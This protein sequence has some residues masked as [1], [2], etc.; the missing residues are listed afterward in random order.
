MTICRIRLRAVAAVAAMTF[1]SAALA[2]AQDR[3]GDR[4]TTY[5][6][7]LKDGSRCTESSSRRTTPASC[8]AVW[9]AS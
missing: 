8:F 1:L 9:P 6:L 7:T 4:M 5:E 2:A 3:P